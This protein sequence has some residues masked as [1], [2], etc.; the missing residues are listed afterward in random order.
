[1]IYAYISQGMFIFSGRHCLFVS[2]YCRLF[3]NNDIDGLLK[4]R[5]NSSELAAELSLSCINQS[6]CSMYLLRNIILRKLFLCSKSLRIIHI[7][8]NEYCPC[9][10][11]HI[12]WHPHIRHADVDPLAISMIFANTTRSAMMW[13]VT[14]M[15][16]RQDIRYSKVVKISQIYIYIYIYIFM[17]LR[18]CYGS[19]KMLSSL[20]TSR[21]HLFGIWKYV[22]PRVTQPKVTSVIA[23]T[24]NHFG[25][26]RIV[27]QKP[28][29]KIIK[30][31]LR[32]AN[33]SHN[34]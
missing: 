22:K 4:V 26:I 29:W 23:D 12:K 21:C 14:E 32:E 25:N 11:D 10:R 30:Y 3:R 15:F 16:Q 27:L 9:T 33:L 5:R 7:G 17:Q 19:Q 31:S 2:W 28:D 1:M 34:T 20:K 13:F 24:L 6:L 18:F 8:I